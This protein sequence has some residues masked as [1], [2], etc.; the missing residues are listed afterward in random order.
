MVRDA[1]EVFLP[2]WE[3]T[4]GND[5]YVSFEVDPLL[6]DPDLNLPHRQRVSQYIELG[7]QVVGRP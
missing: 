5:G 7:Q 3:Q 2:V 4:G 1:Q 6:E